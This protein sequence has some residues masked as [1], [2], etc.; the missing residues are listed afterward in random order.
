MASISAEKGVRR[1][2]S[3]ASTVGT[4]AMEGLFPDS[5]TAKILRRYED[6]ELTLDEFSA[7]M[8]AHALS[9]QTTRSTLV[10]AA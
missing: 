3:V 10:G 1:R 9:L 5:V 7:A 2:E 6:G 4:H 8:D